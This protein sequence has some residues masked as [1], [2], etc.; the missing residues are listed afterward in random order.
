[1]AEIKVL[2]EGVHK[3]LEEEK[4]EIG[5]TTTLIKSDKTIIVD[6]GAFINKDKL[7]NALK[8]E[9]LP[10]EKIDFVILT[11]LHLDHI[12][13][14]SLF[15]KAK[16]FLKFINGKYPGQFQKIDQGILE[17]FNI[18]TEKIAEDVEIIETPGH[19]DDHISILVKTKEGNIVIAGDAVSTQDFANP[20]KQ[21]IPNVF[22]SD[23]KF[24]ESRDKILKIAD[25]II[26]GHGKMF[27]VEK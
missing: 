13:N 1:M 19:S 11:H 23:A 27:K 4:F 26:P 18:L 12:V 16:I 25:Y 20:K 2:I 7:L 8:K 9:D 14:V 15:S 5:C 24:N 22:Y 17:R 6:P 10:P 3:H 21:P